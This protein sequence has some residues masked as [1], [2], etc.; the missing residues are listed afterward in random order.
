MKVT[1]E[2]TTSL[3]KSVLLE[4]AETAGAYNKS[5]AYWAYDVPHGTPQEVAPGLFVTVVAQ[6][7][8]EYDS[9]GS[10]NTGYIVFRF[11]SEDEGEE[12]HYKVDGYLSS[13]DSDWNNVSFTRVKGVSRTVTVWE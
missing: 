10:N 7:N 5:W 8:D 1:R 6:G 2:L 4:H 11:L 9:Y 12:Q 13:Y 3:A